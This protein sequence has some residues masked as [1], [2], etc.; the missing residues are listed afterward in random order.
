MVEN[1]YNTIFHILL[2][3]VIISTLK[4]HLN[5]AGWRL[6]GKGHMLYSWKKLTQSLKHTHYVRNITVWTACIGSFSGIGL[7]K[8]EERTR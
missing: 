5:L 3:D 2:H 7:G 6:G 1:S 8:L 4:I